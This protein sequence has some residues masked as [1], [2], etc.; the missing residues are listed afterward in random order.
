MDANGV[1]LWSLSLSL[2]V[3]YYIFFATLVFGI[4]RLFFVILFAF[5]E[6]YHMTP[7]R[8]YTKEVIS[9][10][11]IVPAYNEEK[12]ISKTIDSLLMS[13]YTHFDII[14]VDD[15]STDTTVEIVRKQ[16]GDNPRVRILEKPNSGK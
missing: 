5:F 12:V 2:W 14:V 16:Y 13:H 8:K 6:K 10:S 9:T 3:I 15:G 7:N 1:S 4:I 11:V